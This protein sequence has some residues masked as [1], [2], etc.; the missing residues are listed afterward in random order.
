MRASTAMF[1]SVLSVFCV[2]AVVRSSIVRSAAMR[3]LAVWKSD[4]SPLGDAIARQV[5]ALSR[6]KRA[7]ADWPFWDE[8]SSTSDCTNDGKPYYECVE[9]GWSNPKKKRCLRKL[10]NRDVQCGDTTL[11]CRGGIGGGD[12]AGTVKGWCDTKTPEE[13]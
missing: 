8:C 2:L 7:A 10:C 1:L 12:Q 9:I 6:E 13:Y 4:G 11:R 3:D 5:A